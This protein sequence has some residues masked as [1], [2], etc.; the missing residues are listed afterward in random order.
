MT[1][2]YNPA[3]DTDQHLIELHLGYGPGENKAVDQELWRRYPHLQGWWM[4]A[5]WLDKQ[6]TDTWWEARGGFDPWATDG[7]EPLPAAEDLRRQYQAICEGIAADQPV[8][9]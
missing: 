6:H 2:T 3:R 1:T 8:Y 4:A 9:I 5:N 7:P